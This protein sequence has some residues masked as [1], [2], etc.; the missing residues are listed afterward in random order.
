M[1]DR[2]R[3]IRMAVFSVWYVDTPIEEL[4]AAANLSEGSFIFAIND[5]RETKTPRTFSPHISFSRQKEDKNFL[6][7]LL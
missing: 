6:S 1:G 3:S 4:F 7:S 2:N 5:S